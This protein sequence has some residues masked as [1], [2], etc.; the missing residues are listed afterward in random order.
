MRGVSTEASAGEREAFSCLL[1]Y[2]HD[3]AMHVQ[4]D[5][6]WHE[7][8]CVQR[9]VRDCVVVEGATRVCGAECVGLRLARRMMKACW[10]FLCEGRGLVMGVSIS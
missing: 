2:A 6:L 1:S 4:R 9:E 7:W 3:L 8:Q 10:V 5:I